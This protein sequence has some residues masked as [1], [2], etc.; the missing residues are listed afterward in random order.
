MIDLKH[1][2]DCESMCTHIKH[3]IFTISINKTIPR[4]DQCINLVPKRGLHNM[5]HDFF[6]KQIVFLEALQHKW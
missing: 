3:K 6:T 5:Y 4:T 1:L 2:W